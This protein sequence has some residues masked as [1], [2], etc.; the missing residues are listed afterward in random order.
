M[1]EGVVKPEPV[2]SDLDDVMQFMRDRH[3]E[4]REAPVRGGIDEHVV[5]VDGHE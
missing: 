3:L 4:C 2:M 5:I 1:V